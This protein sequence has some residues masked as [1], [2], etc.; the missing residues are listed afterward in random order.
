MDYSK[1]ID[2]IYQG[3]NNEALELKNSYVPSVLYKYYSLDRR[4]K[5][6]ELNLIP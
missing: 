5:L 1:Y 6:N 4:T 3:K 2:L